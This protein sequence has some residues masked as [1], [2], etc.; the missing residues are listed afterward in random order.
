MCQEIKGL[1]EKMC[2]HEIKRGYMK[3]IFVVFMLNKRMLKKTQYELR[4]V[5]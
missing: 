1:R 4:F 5:K 2:L 3:K